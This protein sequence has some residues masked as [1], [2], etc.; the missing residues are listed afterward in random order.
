MDIFID[1]FKKKDMLELLIWI[2][3][4][5]SYR[6]KYTMREINRFSVISVYT[7]SYSSLFSTWHNGI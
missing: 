5:N 6:I 2:N 7:S 4:L 1:R 3:C